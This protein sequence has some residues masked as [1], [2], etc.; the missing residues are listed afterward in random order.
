MTHGWSGK[1]QNTAGTRG[2]RFKL[3]DKLLFQLFLI[4]PDWYF[5]ETHLRSAGKCQ[6][7][8]SIWLPACAQRSCHGAP[9][10][11]CL[12]ESDSICFT[13]SRIEKVAI[14]AGTSWNGRINLIQA[15]K[16]K[17]LVLSVR[18]QPLWH[19]EQVTITAPTWML[20]SHWNSWPA[21]KQLSSMPYSTEM[22]RLECSGW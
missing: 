1:V 9:P 11:N 22:V 18:R 3:L 12:L 17:C 13:M 14:L 15:R 16:W 19:S 7:V 6:S 10:S 21:D 5:W 2:G 20:P 4:S 8:F